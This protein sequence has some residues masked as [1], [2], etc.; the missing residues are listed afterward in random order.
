MN[1]EAI[2]IDSGTNSSNAPEVEVMVPVTCI[3]GANVLDA[4]CLTVEQRLGAMPGSAT[5]VLKSGR[6]HNGPI[7]LNGEK[8]PVQLGHRCV[9]SV[10]GQTIHAGTIAIRQDQGQKDEVLYTSYDDR[11]LLSQIPLRGCMVWDNGLSGHDP[12]FKYLRRYTLRFNPNGNWNCCPGKFQKNTWPVF[13]A[14]AIGTRT[15]ET[16]EDTFPDALGDPGSEVVPWT[17]RRAL[18]YIWLICHVQH[19]D[20][21]GIRFEEWRNLT[22][23]KRLLWPIESLTGLS[24]LDAVNLPKD[25]LD[26]KLPDMTLQGESVLSAIVKILEV[27]GTHDLTISYQGIGGGDP[28]ESTMGTLAFVPRGLGAR[29]NA[30]RTKTHLSLRRGGPVDDQGAWDFDLRE[31]ITDL[32]ESIY[33]EGAP[34][35]LETTLGY[36][37][38]GTGPV[39]NGVADPECLKPGWTGDNTQ[40]EEYCFKGMINGGTIITGGPSDYC[41]IPAYAGQS[42]WSDT[43]A[44]A[45]L[46]C[47]GTGGRPLILR[48]TK[49][50]I[51]MARQC[52]PNVFKSFV[53]DSTAA[54]LKLRGFNKEY[55][56]EDEFPV[57]SGPRPV[58]PQQAQFVLRSLN[59][60][61]EKEASWNRN[62]YPVRLR[63]K[64]GSEW[65]DTVFNIGLR[66]TGDYTLWLDGVSEALDGQDQCIYIGTLQDPFHV[67]MRQLM[68]NIVIPMDHRLSSYQQIDPGDSSLPLDYWQDMNGPPLLYIDSPNAY[69]EVHQI[70][71]EPGAIVGFQ[72]GTDKNGQ[73]TYDPAPLNR[74]LPP[75][76]EQTNIDFAA[77]RRLFWTKYPTRESTW[78][79]MGIDTTW[80]AGTWID[81][82]SV[83]GGVNAQEQ[84]YDLGAPI[85]S[86]VFDFQSQVTTVGGLASLCTFNQPR[87]LAGGRK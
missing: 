84:N 72:S 21:Q 42:V 20:V 49:N 45:F 64:S 47:D 82:V 8:A 27:A 14:S 59:G 80:A 19:G 83:F 17:P 69:H 36:Y 4:H 10:Q 53:I 3:D 48:R 26:R 57:L 85:A 33:V 75:G 24:G 70:D 51:N 28:S 23:S 52:Y 62:V 31:S 2:N 32:R 11:F 18:Q 65:L 35:V 79:L 60:V 12:D 56:N 25:P 29:D 66:M 7:T 44:D 9:V 76:S 71:S 15:Y 5:I 34:V 16:S 30:Q 50:A 6:D 86:V 40:G 81:E 43:G 55:D 54:K 77:K 37:K 63:V 1:N 68:L 13:A 78:R 87:I 39:F 58:R 74:L 61:N 46:P 41:M 38:G 73:A 22:K 67:S